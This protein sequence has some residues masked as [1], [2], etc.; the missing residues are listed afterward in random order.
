M[1]NLQAS[2]EFYSSVLGFHVT[3][4]V[5]GRFAFMTGGPMHHELALQQAPPSASPASHHSLGLYHVAFE[6]DSREELE[7]A[8][9]KVRS[10]GLDV[11]VVD[12]GISLAAYSDDLDGNG[13]EI[14]LDTRTAT[15]GRTVWK[16]NS[17][18]VDI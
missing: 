18:P 6:V 9:A 14:Y 2:K 7:S 5:A 1:N 12:H 8:I 3:E 10:F 4:E 16:G 17:T 15:S 13:L 11:Q